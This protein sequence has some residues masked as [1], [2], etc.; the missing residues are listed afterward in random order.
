MHQLIMR[1]LDVIDHPVE[2][3]FA[4]NDTSC[5][6]GSQSNTH[7]C[8]ATYFAENRNATALFFKTCCNYFFYLELLRFF[9]VDNSLLKRAPKCTFLVVL[10]SGDNQF[11]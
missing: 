9:I 8:G 2:K 3:D 7:I 4:K 6:Y 5:M 1:D 11:F 10:A